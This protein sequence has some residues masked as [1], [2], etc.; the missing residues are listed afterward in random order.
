MPEKCAAFGCVNKPEIAA[1]VKQTNDVYDYIIPFCM[2]CNTKDYELS[3][4]DFYLVSVNEN[5]FCTKIEIDITVQD[6]KKLFCRGKRLI[7]KIFK[8]N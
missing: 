6:D 2:E 4:W 3:V 7:K 8:S 5:D 1:T